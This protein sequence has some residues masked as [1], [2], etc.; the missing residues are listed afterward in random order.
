MN[1]PDV[2]MLII[3]ANIK[4]DKYIPTLS[5]NRNRDEDF[6]SS[7]NA[8]EHNDKIHPIITFSKPSN[9]QNTND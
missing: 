7:H 1:A 6:V 2:K 9:D 8:E 4:D 3:N 5:N